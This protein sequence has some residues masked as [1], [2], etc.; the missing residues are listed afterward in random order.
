[1]PVPRG[2]DTKL[3]RGFHF[4]D[5]IAQTKQIQF[6]RLVFEQIAVGD[7]VTLSGR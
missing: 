1:V 5:S 3:A 2:A 4:F 7:F 6:L